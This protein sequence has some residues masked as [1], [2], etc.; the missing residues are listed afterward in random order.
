MLRRESTYQPFDA[1]DYFCY[2][3]GTHS[4]KWKL[5]GKPAP[6]LFLSAAQLLNVLP[7]RAAV[8]E[9][10]IL[11]IQAA[12]A[13]HFGLVVGVARSGNPERLKQARADRVISKLTELTEVPSVQSGWPLKVT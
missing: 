2:V 4:E 3:D 9:D 12:P 5:R 13:G 1:H 10:A 11:G 6:D 7:S 8:I